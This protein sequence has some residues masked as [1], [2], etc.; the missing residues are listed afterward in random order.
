M[1]GVMDNL[2]VGGGGA[3]IC[4]EE[5]LCTNIYSMVERAQKKGGHA[6]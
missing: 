5:H 4:S 1:L 3:H 2:R 6:L